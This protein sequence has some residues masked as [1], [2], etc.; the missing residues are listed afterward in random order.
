MLNAIQKIF[1][2]GMFAEEYRRDAEIVA[3][4]LAE[5]WK[6]M[7]AESRKRMAKLL[8]D[9]IERLKAILKEVSRFKYKPFPSD[10]YQNF[11]YM[12]TGLESKVLRIRFGDSRYNAVKRYAEELALIS[13]RLEDLRGD[14]LKV[15]K[16]EGMPLWYYNVP[17]AKYK[18]L[19]REV[20]ERYY[21]LYGEPISVWVYLE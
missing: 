6:A 3:R 18:E 14:L 5:K 20:F 4:K 11:A 9:N 17:S 2:Y 12:L 8:I 16:G 13:Y 19:E 7:D 15:M 21:K 1:A 10:V